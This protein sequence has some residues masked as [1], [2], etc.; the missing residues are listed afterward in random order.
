MLLLRGAFIGSRYT[1][2]GSCN[3]FL[4]GSNKFVQKEETSYWR[5]LCAQYSRVSHASKEVA[6]FNVLTV[7]AVHKV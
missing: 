5:G 6:D 3:N 7:V 2:L 4:H 1:G